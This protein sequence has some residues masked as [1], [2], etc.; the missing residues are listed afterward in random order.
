MNSKYFYVSRKY[1]ANT[2]SSTDRLKLQRSKLNEKLAVINDKKEVENEIGEQNLGWQL[3]RAV[4][5]LDA[6]KQHL[7]TAQRLLDQYRA[8]NKEEII[9]PAN[10]KKDN[11]HAAAHASFD[12]ATQ[13]RD[14]AIATAN[15][16]IAAAHAAFELATQ[17]RD[18]A[19]AAANAAFEHVSKKIDGKMSTEEELLVNRVNRFTSAVKLSEQNVERL[20]SNKSK[21]VIRVEGAEKKIVRE[22][23]FVSEIDDMNKRQEENKSSYMSKV[24]APPDI[25]NMPQWLIDI[26]EDPSLEES[27][28]D[29]KKQVADRIRKEEEEME[30]KKEINDKERRL[31]LAAEEQ[32][33]TDNRKKELEVR[34]AKLSGRQASFVEDEIFKL[35]AT[36][37][38]KMK[39]Y[40]KETE[41][42]EFRRRDAEEEE[43]YRKEEERKRLQ[44]E[45]EEYNNLDQAIA[46]AKERQRQYYKLHGNS[47]HV[48]KKAVKSVGIK[49]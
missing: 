34:A 45:E 37:E 40:E 17:K 15:N 11:A 3:N 35:E 21:G 36:H 18:A 42:E 9:Q 39:Q 31:M 26:G 2:S 29:A 32:R 8:K 46:E 27:R 13:K 20:Q 28:K 22:L 16:A 10:I 19:I 33:Q 49:V 4:C 1:M 47:T 43:K 23:T 24:T 7:E 6:N 30:R 25:S 41:M 5:G 48:V 44:E 38:Y 12:V 14:S